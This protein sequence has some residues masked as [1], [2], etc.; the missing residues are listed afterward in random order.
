VKLVNS[1]LA[2]LRAVR[3]NKLRSV[4]TIVRTE[5]S[6]PEIMMV[7]PA[8]DGV[9]TYETGSLNRPKIRRIFV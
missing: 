1:T 3:V 6:N 8:Q 2:A 4:L 9:R 7:K 5:N